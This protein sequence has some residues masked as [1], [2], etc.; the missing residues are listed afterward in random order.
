MNPACSDR[1]EVIAI[2]PSLDFRVYETCKVKRF[3]EYPNISY[4]SGSFLEFVSPVKSNL[5]YQITIYSLSRARA[6]CEVE[7]LTLLYNDCIGY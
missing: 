3:S 6:A 5:K 2:T 1:L 4:D 7:V